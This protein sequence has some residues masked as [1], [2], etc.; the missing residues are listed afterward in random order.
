MKKQKRG[1]RITVVIADQDCVLYVAEL[2]DAGGG[3]ANVDQRVSP[4]VNLLMLRDMFLKL[5]EV[6]GDMYYTARVK[7]L[8]R[9]AR[10]E[11]TARLKEDDGFNPHPF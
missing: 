10:D 1:T 6:Q 9:E 8:S 7:T 4:E 11:I 2:T 5:S 3:A